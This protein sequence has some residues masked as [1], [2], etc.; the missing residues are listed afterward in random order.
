[1]PVKIDVYRVGAGSSGIWATVAD[2]PQT[3]WHTC[4]ASLVLPL[5]SSHRGDS[6]VPARNNSVMMP[7]TAGLA[8]IQR[9]ASGPSAD[10]AHPIAAAAAAPPAHTTNSEPRSRPRYLLG[11]NSASRE[12]AI[13]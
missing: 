7:N 13:G 10:S 11:I 2:G 1:M 4:C 9:H 6:G 3:R 12:L 8:S 5:L